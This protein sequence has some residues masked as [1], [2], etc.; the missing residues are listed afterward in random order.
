MPL[1]YGRF[2]QRGGAADFLRAFVCAA[3][4]GVQMPLMAMMFSA[5]VQKNQRTVENM[6]KNRH[7]QRSTSLLIF[8]RNSHRGR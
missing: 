8:Y 3:G 6:V 7:F 4:F 5:Q 2:Q 1:D